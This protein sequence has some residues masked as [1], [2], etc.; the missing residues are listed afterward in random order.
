MKNI[1]DSGERTEFKTGAVRDSQSLKG[2]CDLMP[3]EELIRTFY[4]HEERDRDI[5]K[6]FDRTRQYLKSGMT[7][8]AIAPIESL[9]VAI[10]YDE[11]PI[12]MILQL[13]VHFE[14]GA[15]KY[16]ID[17]WQKGIPMSSYLSSAIRHYLKWIGKYDD[18]NHRIACM[19]NLI[20]LYWTINKM[21]EMND[22]KEEQ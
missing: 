4:S 12:D 13:S 9:I 7:S 10:T 19:W 16:G 2:R 1:V 20:C 17:N 11:D 8:E 21:P 6:M 15:Q 18:E 3:M 14:Q 5:G 22:Y